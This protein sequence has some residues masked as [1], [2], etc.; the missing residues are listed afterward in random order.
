MKKIPIQCRTRRV[1]VGGD[2]MGAQMTAN[3][4][5]RGPRVQ[6]GQGYLDR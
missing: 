3:L 2:S 1:G 4:G 6:A 5:F